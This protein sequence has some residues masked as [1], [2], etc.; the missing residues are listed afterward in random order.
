MSG[1]SCLNPNANIAIFFTII[2]NSHNY[3]FIKTYVANNRPD[4]K[5]ME[6]PFW[7]RMS[8]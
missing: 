6:V 5:L 3:F 1:K 2:F 7:L 4:V 8:T